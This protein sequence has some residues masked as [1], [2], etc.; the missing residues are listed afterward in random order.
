M[1][2]AHHMSTSALRMRVEVDV[3]ER[4]SPTT[5]PVAPLTRAKSAAITLPPVPKD[6]FHHAS[7]ANVQKEYG[8]YVKVGKFKLNAYG[9]WFMLGAIVLAVPWAFVLALQY[10]TIKMVDKIDPARRWVDSACRWWAKNIV[11]FGFSLPELTGTENIPNG[12]AVSAC[13]F[14]LANTYTTG[15]GGTDFGPI[16]R[17]PVCL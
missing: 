8:P 4:P 13:L 11:V 3:K 14:V 12:P 2:P 9:M 6:N 1:H 10:A 15:L 16:Q 7:L 5:A 17:I